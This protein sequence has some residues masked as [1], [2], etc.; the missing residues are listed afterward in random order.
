MEK[1]RAKSP[2]GGAGGMSSPVPGE[3]YFSS[4]SPLY[5]APRTA[6]PPEV[7]GAKINTGTATP[8]EDQEHRESPLARPRRSSP[9]RAEPPQ[10]AQRTASQDPSPSPAPYTAPAVPTA[11]GAGSEWEDEDADFLLT[12]AAARTQK[13]NARSGALKFGR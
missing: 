7:P 1:R 12:W 5:T 6:T 3:G 9:R 10:V 11:G 13:Q 4:P 2:R 8:I